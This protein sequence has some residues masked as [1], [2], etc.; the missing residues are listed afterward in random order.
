MISAIILAAGRSKRMGE[1]KLLMPF[2]GMAMVDFVI[3]TV[4]S[5]KFDGTFAVVSRETM[6]CLAPIEGVDYIVNPDPDRGQMSSLHCGLSALPFNSSFAVLLA[7][8]PAVTAEQVLDL[9]RRFQSLNHK[10]AL[11]PLKGGAPGHPAFYS[12]LWRGRFLFS[13]NGLAGR[14]TLFQ[15][16]EDVE[17][18]EED[19]NDNVYENCFADVDTP[20]DYRKLCSFNPDTQGL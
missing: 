8:K 17:W 4:L 16:K 2:R 10:S 15:Y 5:C 12:H 1:Q 6:D 18:L 11:V 13:V 20:E 19:A 9:C 7:D 14:D 3:K